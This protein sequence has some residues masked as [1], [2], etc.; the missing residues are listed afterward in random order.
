ATHWA[1]SAVVDFIRRKTLHRLVSVQDYPESEVSPH[2]RINGYPPISA[3]PQ[4]KGGDDTYEQLLANDF[5][6]YRLEVSGLVETPL[7][8]SLA[9]LR[10][11]PRQEQTTL[12][13]CIQGWTSIGRWGGVPVREILDRCRP[14]PGA[15]YLVFHSFGMHEYSGK[16]Y[17]ECV[18]MKIGY[19]PQTI[20]AYELN[21]EPLP[22]QHGAPLRP[23]F[24]T[25]LGF[26]M[27]KFLRAIEVVDDYRMVGDGMGGAREDEQQF[28]MGAEI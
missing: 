27:T 15:K 2:F 11:M 26:K 24:E 22:L 4:A 20:L 14:L 21:G 6:D 5:A 8:L 28:D 25:K 3:Y 1:L 12:H 17:Y 18:A 9:E 13:H 10:A 7:S 23:R 16:P 19:H